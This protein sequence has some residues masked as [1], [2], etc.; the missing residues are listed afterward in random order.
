M[1][2]LKRQINRLTSELHTTSNPIATI[3]GAFSLM[4]EATLHNS[5]VQ[6]VSCRH[7]D[8]DSIVLFYSISLAQQKERDTNFKHQQI[9]N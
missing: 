6:L 1:K 8:T 5:V 3:D 9:R 2:P 7:T 4:E